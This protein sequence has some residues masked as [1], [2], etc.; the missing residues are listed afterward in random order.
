MS[1]EAQ[2]GSADRPALSR[3]VSLPESR[4]ADEHW[5]S[6]PLLSRSSD[7]AHPF[8]DLFSADA[9][10]EL[11]SERGLRTPFVRMA[12]EGSV[13]PAAS[14][15]SA[16]GYGAEIAD[17]LDSEKVLS[18]FAAGSTIVLQG[19]H[20]TWGP[21][22]AFTR[23][24]VM[25]LGHPC[26]VNAYIT[27]ASSRGFDPHYDVHDVFVVQIAGEKH[28]TIH[29]PVHTDPLAG[30]PWTD[31][32]AAVARRATGSAAID[33]TFRPGDVLYLPRGWIH[34]A[35]ALGGTSIHLTIGVAAL[36]RFDAL[37]Q[38]VEGLAADADLR[39]SLP[40]GAGFADAVELERSIGSVLDDAVSRLTTSADSLLPS[41]AARLQQRV[42]RSTR[43]EPLRPVA[44][45]ASIE[46]LDTDSGVQW[47]DGLAMRI[48]EASESVSIGLDGRSITLPSLAT[49]ALRALESGSIT[50][51]G[52]LPGLDEDSAVVVARRL[53]REG[54]LVVRS[55]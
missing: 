34:S 17:Q 12:K 37:Q 24:L 1:T 27:P 35:T 55:A 18:E 23:Q 31:H 19:L 20:R 25:D 13:L 28:W 7:L 14:F 30:Q 4:F 32:R 33:E 41:V 43:P 38:L 3:L 50:R 2:R 8:D 54:V 29:E 10:D 45:A 15:T 11:I 53:V 40:L 5:G 6:T 42:R 49:E 47:R 36:T 39:A 16:G 21:L 44:T 46:S 48:T 22:R 52:D 9:V 51:V 26:Q